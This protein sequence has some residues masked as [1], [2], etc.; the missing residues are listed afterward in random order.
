MNYNPNPFA[1]NTL[2][3]ESMNFGQKLRSSILKMHVIF[4]HKSVICEFH[5]SIP[6]PRLPHR[7]SVDSP[8][9]AMISWKR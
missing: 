8:H 9:G 3:V 6:L 5:G 4:A 2:D 1:K 7:S